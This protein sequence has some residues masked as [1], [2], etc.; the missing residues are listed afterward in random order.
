MAMAAAEMNIVDSSHAHLLLLLLPLLSLLLLLVAF[1]LWPT[2]TNSGGKGKQQS[3]RSRK[4]NKKLP[5]PPSPPGCLPI[6]GHLLHL[7]GDQQQQPH[8]ALR[9]LASKHGG[10]LMLLRLGAVQNI[11]VSSPW[12]AREILRTHD[13]AFASRP[14]SA[15]ATVL[16][17]GPSDVAFAPYGEQ[18][19]QSRKLVTAHL[20]TANKVRSFQHARIDEV[21]LAI[22]KIRDELLAAGGGGVVDMSDLLYSFSNDVVCRAVSGKFFCCF[23]AQG[24]RNRNE[25]F[26]ELIGM[27]TAVLGGF[28]VE[29][30]F[31]RLALL[32]SRVM[33]GRAKKLQKRWHDLLD[34]LIDA[35]ARRNPKE[36]RL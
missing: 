12:A 27:S 22:A 6:V 26:R 36:E 23:T 15:I 32:T 5:L 2:P 24:R 18:W 9:D 35:H 28:N 25:L 33:C 10:G 34:K 19:R 3:R 11:V 13:H 14:P 17:S 30:Y 4:N 8:V 31:P 29:D 7:V 1:L 20:L 21:R 16:F